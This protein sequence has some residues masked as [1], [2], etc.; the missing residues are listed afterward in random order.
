MP[1]GYQQN[2]NQLDTTLY[3][4]TITQSGGTATWTTAGQ[5]AGGVNPYDWGAYTTLPSSATNSLNLAQG[6]VRWLSIVE[7]LSKLADCRIYDM[8]IN[9]GSG[10]T[11]GLPASPNANT[12]VTS[13]AFDVAYDRD[14]FILPGYQKILLSE[15]ASNTSFVGYGG[16]SNY[17]TTTA[18]A[19]RELVTRAI[20]RGTTVSNGWYKTH[21]VYNPTANDDTETKVYVQQPDVPA[22]IWADIGVTQVADSLTGS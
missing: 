15:N 10:A 18:Q 20:I 8:T 21:R 19:I 11:S 5:T 16:G 3:R 14:S 6:N 17:V 4:V 7:E 9:F 1:S 22:N 12:V 2:P 13:L